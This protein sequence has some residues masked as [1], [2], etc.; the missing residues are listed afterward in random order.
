MSKIGRT[1]TSFGK[2]ALRKCNQAVN[3]RN[4]GTKRSLC[5]DQGQNRRGPLY[6][7]Y[8]LLQRDLTGQQFLFV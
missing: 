4:R 6:K 5:E 1:Q 8:F 2:Q 3:G 7:R